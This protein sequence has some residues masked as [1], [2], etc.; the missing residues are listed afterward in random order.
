VS[1]SSFQFRTLFSLFIENL[2]SFEI[3]LLIQMWL[4]SLSST[5]SLSQQFFWLY[6]IRSSLQFGK[7][8]KKKN[9]VALLKLK[10]LRLS[11][12][13]KENERKE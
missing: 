4:F 2:F 5:L 6:L 11:Q 12:L 13:M 3:E 10:L 9:G 8:N 7:N 1:R